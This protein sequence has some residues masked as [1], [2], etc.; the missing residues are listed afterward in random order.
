MMVKFEMWLVCGGRELTDYVR[1]A[2]ALDRLVD[3]HGRPDRVMHGGARG[4]D[5]LAGRWAQERGIPLQVC[6]AQWNRYGRSAGPIRNQEMLERRPS[7]VVAFPGGMGTADMVQRSVAAGV[8]V[9]RFVS[10]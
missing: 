7:M 6:P 4:A 1:L 9:V 3:K 10:E 5:S 2:A 8:P